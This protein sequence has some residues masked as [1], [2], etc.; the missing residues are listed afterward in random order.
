MKREREREERGEGGEKPT[1]GVK[2]RGGQGTV[3]SVLEKSVTVKMERTGEGR[4]RKER[5]RL[6]QSVAAHIFRRKEQSKRCVRC[7]LY[8]RCMQWEQ[9]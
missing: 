5:I 8:A 7:Y 3:S 2:W 1:E 6:R 9:T 4:M